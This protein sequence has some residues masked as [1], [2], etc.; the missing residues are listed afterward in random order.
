MPFSPL[1]AEMDRILA[2]YPVSKRS[3]AM[4][5]LY[6]IQERYGHISNE[7]IEWA[8]AR[9]ELQPINL[10]ELVTFYP[11]FRQKPVGRHH[12]KVC[13]TLSCMLGGAENLRDHLLKKLDVGLD[14]ITAD[15]KFTVSEVECLACCGT[16]PA[17]MINDVLHENVTPGKT[18]AILKDCA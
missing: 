14:E 6:L 15:G 3:A 10:L 1:N 7:A 8:A 9:L 16:A 5:V 4:P 18:D 2:R 17:M 13:R 12:I 11:M